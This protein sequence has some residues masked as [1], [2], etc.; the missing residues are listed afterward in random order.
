MPTNITNLAA[1]IPT[2]PPPHR[3]GGSWEDRS[4]GGGARQVEQPKVS[5]RRRKRLRHLQIDYSKG[6]GCDLSLETGSCRLPLLSLRDVGCVEL[7]LPYR[8]SNSATRQLQLQDS[9]RRASREQGRGG[10][11]SFAPPGEL[12]LALGISAP[13][14]VLLGGEGGLPWAWVQCLVLVL[15]LP[16]GFA[17]HGR[18]LAWNVPAEGEEWEAPGSMEKARGKL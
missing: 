14:V 4:Q 17:G 11:S 3:L 8:S 5:P 6:Q 15:P 7:E 9:P 2:P 16:G 13:G 18:D 10:N 12:Y 1:S